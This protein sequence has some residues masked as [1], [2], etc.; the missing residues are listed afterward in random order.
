MTSHHFCTRR[1]RSVSL[2][3]RDDCCLATSSD[4]GGD[5]IM[6]SFHGDGYPPP[7]VVVD[8]DPRLRM[9]ASSQ[10]QQQ[11]RRR[12]LWTYERRPETPP[13]YCDCYLG[14]CST[15]G[16]AAVTGAYEEDSPPLSPPPPKGT[17]VVASAPVSLSR[18]L[19]VQNGTETATTTDPRSPTPP[20]APPGKTFRQAFCRYEDDDNLPD[21]VQT[22]IS[23]RYSVRLNPR[24]GDPPTDDSSSAK[25]TISYVVG[26]S[27]PLAPSEHA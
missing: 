10:R 7:C 4:C 3:T 27:V 25:S 8:V 2:A 17:V 6:K 23:F 1:F 20:P 14:I 16:V 26:T 13:P 11:Q 9:S 18:R 22:G 24:P 21:Q 12:R 19:L 5:V 15:E